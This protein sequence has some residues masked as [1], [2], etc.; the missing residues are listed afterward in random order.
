MKLQKL[1]YFCVGW[2]SVFAD[3]DNDWLIENDFEAWPYGPVIPRVYHSVSSYRDMPITKK[4]RDWNIHNRYNNK[5]NSDEVIRQVLEK[6][7]H[8]SDWQ[9]SN[10]T[11]LEGS[12]W[13][14]TISESE[15]Y[16]GAIIDR[17]KIKEYFK[18]RSENG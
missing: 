10:I 3:T 2:Y 13:S 14:K 17:N 9:L 12:P 5:E 15:G 7:G 4:I 18:S 6:Y 11:H 8:F 1:L 16:I